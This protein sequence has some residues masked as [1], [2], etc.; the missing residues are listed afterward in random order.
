M[1]CYVIDINQSYLMSY[2]SCHVMSSCHIYVILVDYYCVYVGCLVIIIAIDLIVMM[3]LMM[4]T[5]AITTLFIKAI[6][7]DGHIVL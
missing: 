3:F 5:M 2:L 7:P 6:S 1:F 4:T